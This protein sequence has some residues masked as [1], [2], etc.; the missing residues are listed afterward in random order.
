MKTSLRSCRAISTVWP[1]RLARLST[2]GRISTAPIRIGKYQNKFPYGSHWSY[3]F[4]FAKDD[5]HH[6]S[7]P[8]DQ[9]ILLDRGVDSFVERYVRI[10]PELRNRDLYLYE[11]TGDYYWESEYF[12][13]GKAA[14]FRCSFL[15]H[16]EPAANPGTKVEIFEYQPTVWVGEYFGLSAHAILPAKLHDIRPGAADYRGPPRSVA[17]DPARPLLRRRQARLF[18]PVRPPKAHKS[19]E[20]R[21]FSPARKRRREA[22]SSLPSAGEGCAASLAASIR[23]RRYI[24][25]FSQRWL[26]A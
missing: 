10:P 26:I 22:P 15:I 3:F 5:A 12:Y 23:V 17:I 1:R 20:G 11:P 18:S 8:S 19:L 14:K 16:L 25:G 6:S 21:G 4:L 2:S 7:F 13:Q 24:G 9:E